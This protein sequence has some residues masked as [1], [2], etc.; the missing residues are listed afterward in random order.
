[1]THRTRSLLDMSGTGLSLIC[2][3][4]CLA[5]PTAAVAAPAL[6]P[7]LAERLSLVDGRAHLI[8]FLLAAPVT[9][10]AFFWGERTMRAGR[11]TMAFAGLGLVLMLTG[12]AH[13]VAQPVETILT[14]T[15][16]SLL[17]GAHIANWR[18]RQAE[19]HVHARDCG[20]CED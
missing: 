10:L 1:M 6:A 2:L 18:R 13:I 20:M 5:L 14:V 9:L 4:H 15:G 16:V 7:E 19:G 17:M 12:A 11:W 8:L 3:L